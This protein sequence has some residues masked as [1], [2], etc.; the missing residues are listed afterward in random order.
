MKSCSRLKY[1]FAAFLALAASPAMAYVMSSTNYRIERDSIDMGGGLSDSASYSSE[2]T[3]GGIG[4]GTG[5]S[6]SYNLYAGYQQMDET[7]ISLTVPGATAMS[8]AISPT[9]GG[10]ATASASINVSTNNS[11]GYT[12]QVKASTSPALK[13]GANSFADYV[14]AGAAPDYAFALPSAS[15]SEFAYTPEG[16]DIVARYK[17]N[18]SSC[19]QALGSSTADTCWDPFSTSYATIAQSAAG[20]LPSGTATNVKFRAEAGASANQAAGTY[21][22]TIIFTAFTN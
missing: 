3:I 11:A 12:L 4:S 20:N 18:G 8:P 1:L 9:D 7:T 21:T 6:T 10:A 2:S 13:S 22:A 16:A 17:D 14:L 5:T 15:A 19:N